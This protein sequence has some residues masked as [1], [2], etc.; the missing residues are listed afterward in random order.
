MPLTADHF[1]MGMRKVDPSF[2]WTDF[3]AKEC[4]VADWEKDGY[5]AVGIIHQQSGV[6]H[7]IA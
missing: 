3:R 5:T 1:A 2:Q 6:P 7:G 4:S